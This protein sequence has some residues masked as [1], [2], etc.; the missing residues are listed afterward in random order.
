A[1]LPKLLG[2][3]YGG[4]FRVTRQVMH[5]FEAA[6]EPGAFSPERCP[7]FIWELP[8]RP[9]GIYGFPSIEEAGGGIKVATPLGGAAVDPDR[10]ERTVTP[11]EIAAMY[12]DYVVPYLPGV[13]P[14]SLRTEV[15]MYTEAPGGRFVVDAH[16]EHGRV[17]VASA[18]SG[19]GFKHSAALGEALAERLTAGGSRIDLAPFSLASLREQAAAMT[20]EQRAAYEAWMARSGGPAS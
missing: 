3:P 1:W 5:W 7:V 11:G 17:T 13:G 15:C 6:G 20:P 8:D 14:R 2:R 12:A 18:C 16:P 9:Q 4:L 10:V 19:H